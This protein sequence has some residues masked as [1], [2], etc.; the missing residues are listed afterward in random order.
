MKLP[1]IVLVLITVCCGNLLAQHHLGLNFKAY[2]ATG[3]FQ[4]NVK[5]VPLGLSFAYLRQ[6]EESRFSWGGEL[7]IAMYSNKTY[8][9]E[10]VEEGYPGE[11]TSVDEEDCFWTIHG[12]ARYDLYSSYNFRTYAEIRLGMTTFFSTRTSA[13]EDERFNNTSEFHGTAFN[14]GLGVGLM[15]NPK[16][17]FSKDQER[18]RLWVNLGANFHSG[19]HTTYRNIDSENQSYSL[20]EG[21]FQSLT[22][23]VGYRLGVIF[24]L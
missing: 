6:G 15:L 23:Y 22:H 8:Q 9:Y 12:F 11:Y 17:M 13:Q 7:G 14:S 24:S 4:D 19:S 10:L 1:V 2:Q 3:A 5:S 18:G 16:G 21:K 20:D